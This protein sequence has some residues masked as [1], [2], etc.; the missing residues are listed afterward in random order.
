MKRLWAQICFFF[1]SN[2]NLKG[3]FTGKIYQGALKNICVPGLNC[4]S[5]PGA[6]GSCPIGSLQ[7]V[8]GSAKYNISLYAAGFLALF[9][10]F[11]GRFICGWLCPFG[12]VQDLMYKIKTKKI[13]AVKK[14]DLPLRYLKYAV[15][16]VTA[17]LLPIFAVNDFGIGEPFFCQYLCPSGTLFGG[18][19]LLL[20]NPSLRK[21]AGL[22]FSWKMAVLLSLLTL[23]VL[24]YRPFCKY[25]CPLGAVY[26]LF[27]KI[28]VYQIKVDKSKCTNCKTCEHIC[29]MQVPVSSSPKHAE[30][31]RC[32]EC[33][34]A[35]KTGALT[36][37][38]GIDLKKNKKESPCSRCE[39]SK[40]SA[41]LSLW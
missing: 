8:L 31:I 37:G 26:A 33:K 3:F 7:A 41:D 24:L 18:I 6:L 25:L 22:L 23:S 32:G 34:K 30:C 16:I 1:A 15:L 20:A 40:G 11:L 17:I 21:A 19:P 29:K 10:T 2:L 35:C 39:S 28:S 4:Y 14:I 27:N 13:K 12:L 9:G 38:F 5:C 36:A